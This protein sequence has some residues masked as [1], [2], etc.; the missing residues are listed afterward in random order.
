M[1]F[2]E[3]LAENEVTT[4]IKQTGGDV[5]EGIIVS[6]EVRGYYLAKACHSR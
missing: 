3:V 6:E 4:G 2:Y 1:F 5:V